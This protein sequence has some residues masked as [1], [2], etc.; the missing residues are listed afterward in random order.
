[1]GRRHRI[2]VILGRLLGIFGGRLVVEHDIE[3]GGHYGDRHD[4]IDAHHVDRFGRAVEHLQLRRRL[5]DI[6]SRVDGAEFGRRPHRK[7]R[8][9]RHRAERVHRLRLGACHFRRIGR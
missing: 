6:Q 7:L 4:G 9:E 1:V 5:A 8:T 3:S 2:V